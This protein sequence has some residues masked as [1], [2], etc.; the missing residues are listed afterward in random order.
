VINLS[1]FFKFQIS[2]VYRACSFFT[3]L[4]L[5]C[6]DNTRVIYRKI[7]YFAYLYSYLN[8][9]TSFWGNSRSLKK[10]YLTTKKGNKVN[11]KYFKH[12]TLQ[13]ILQKIKDYDTTFYT[14]VYKIL[15]HTKMYLSKFK[16]NSIFHAYDIRNKSYLFI[17]SH[18]SKLFEQS[19]AYTGVLIYNNL[20]H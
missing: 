17:R 2:N 11:S 4:D 3:S 9:G 20:S 14:H 1:K 7:Q 16:I 13:T 18:K 6:I 15:L 5:F 8:N 12:N 19:I 10:S